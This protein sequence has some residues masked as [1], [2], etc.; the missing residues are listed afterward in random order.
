MIRRCGVRTS[1][2]WTCSAPSGSRN[3]CRPIT[4]C[5]A[6]VPCATRRSPPLDQ[7]F[8]ALYSRMGRPSIPPEMLLRA[9][10]PSGVLFGALRAPADGEI[11]YNLLF[12]WFVGLRMDDRVWD[13]STFSHNRE[14]LLAGEVTQEF[15]G[16]AGEPARGEGVDVARALLGRRHADRRLGLSQKLR[17]EEAMTA[18]H[19]PTGPTAG[20]TGTRAS[21]ARSAPT[22]PTRPPPIPT[23]GSTA[24]PTGARAGCASWA[25]CSSR[26]H[27]EPARAGGGRDGDPRHRHGRARGGAGAHR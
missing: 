11:D 25:T 3:G 26:A 17:E 21:V 19:R 1:G 12:R 22:R 10:P 20:A 13:A 23:R 14:R 15:S 2:R 27:G 18:R 9:T 7:R 6:S 8:A 5:A 4:R 16:R 24:R